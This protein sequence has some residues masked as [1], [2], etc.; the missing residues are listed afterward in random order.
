MPEGSLKRVCHASSNH[1]LQELAFFFGQRNQIGSI[2]SSLIPMDD[3]FSIGFW[4]QST[5]PTGLDN[6]TEC[7]HPVG[8]NS[9]LFSIGGTLLQA[10]NLPQF[11]ADKAFVERVAR[12]SCLSDTSIGGMMSHFSLA[13]STIVC[14]NASLTN[15]ES[16]AQTEKSKKHKHNF[17]G[18]GAAKRMRNNEDMALDQAQVASHVAGEMEEDEIEFEQSAEPSSPY[19]ATDKPRGK[20]TKDGIE[21]AKDKFIHIRARRGQATNSHS[22][23]ERVRREKINERMKLLQDLVPG[24]SK[25][26]GKAVMLDEIINYVRSLQQQVEF[27]SMKLAAIN[28]SLDMDID[29][30]LSKYQLQSCNGTPG[31]IAFPSC[32]VRP[33][34]HLSHLSLVKAGLQGM[35]NP[36]DSLGR[37]IDS[38]TQIAALH[39]YKESRLQMAY[40]N[41]VNL[42]A[43]GLQQ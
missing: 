3:P 26:T 25:I 30:V 19:V 22:L 28:P 18:L 6:P 40:R 38:Q 1:S 24:C 37:S 17:Y 34:L 41:N 8:E 27:L 13:Q 39:G 2:S 9:S 10:A 32:S 33:Q 14:A 31:A 36:P 7:R 29:S 20:Q 35:V 21:S 43:H 12:L 16:E 5:K 4:N 23:A 11:P 42:N 15:A